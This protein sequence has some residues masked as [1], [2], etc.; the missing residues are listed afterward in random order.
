VSRFVRFP[1]RQPRVFR[2][3]RR[4][5][6]RVITQLE[7]APAVLSIEGAGISTTSATAAIVQIGVI[8]GA[9]TTTTSAT[10]VVTLTGVISGTAAASTTS[11]TGDIVRVTPIAGAASSTTS[12]TGEL[13]IPPQP[14][15]IVGTAQADSAGSNVNTAAVTIPVTAVAGNVGLFA[16][17]QGG[18]QVITGPT[19]DGVAWTQ[20][21]QAAQ[22]S[23]PRLTIY[24]KI[25]TA[26]DPGAT[27]QA[28][29][30]AAQNSNV[31]LLVFGAASD[32]DA[33]STAGLSGATAISTITT[34]AVTP[35]ADDG[36]H[37]Y[38][39]G[40]RAG[41]TNTAISHTPPGGGWTEDT[42]VAGTGTGNRLASTTGHLLL[43]G[44]G[45]V[46][47]STQTVTPSTNAT[48]VAVSIV[49]APTAVGPGTL[50]IAGI[51][52]TVTS[53]TGSITAVEVISGAA[54][55]TTSATG[56]VTTRSVVAGAAVTTTSAT[57][58]LTRVTPIAG[59]AVSTTSATGAVT[60]RGALTGAATTVTSATAALT[61]VTPISGTAAAS[62]TSATGDL[63]ITSGPVTW[64]IAGAAATA[65]SAT[66]AVTLRGALTGTS[67]TTTSAVGTLT[68]RMMISAAGVTTT[69]ATGVLT[70]RMVI[71]ASAAVSTTSA[72]GTL[73]IRFP[74][75]GSAATITTASGGLTIPSPLQFGIGVTSEGI[76]P[77][78]LIGSGTLALGPQGRT[79]VAAGYTG[80]TGGL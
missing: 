16:V 29:F 8:S 11:A 45:G 10:A 80:M 18:T 57:G 2:F 50:S 36:L 26:G 28:S 65:T 4:Y 76:V 61:R 51:A 55:T 40:S 60:L 66:A 14:I 47:Q 9:A 59:A 79:S 3:P 12:A 22:G 72:S 64:S 13:T 52:D 1:P 30:A 17:T 48:W 6:S 68:Q 5:K 69:S 38:V 71:S 34:P 46:A 20:Q 39:I 56:A 74:I 24:S 77:V 49:I 78:G 41:T 15:F 58:A 75:A 27:V 63:T 35:L 37:V 23:T 33:V 53:A 7:T 67:A 31:S 25:L 43:S 19:T 54:V 42:D 70:Q 21:L 32:I 62:T 44:Q 73:T